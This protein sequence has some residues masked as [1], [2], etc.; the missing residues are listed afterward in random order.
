MES[1]LEAIDIEQDEYT[2]YDSQGRLLVLK[3]EFENR[4]PNQE[5]KVEAA[6]SE[7]GHQDEL[8]NTLIAY[9]KAINVDDSFL[10]GKSNEQMI[11]M[12]VERSG[13]AEDG[14]GSVEGETFFKLLFNL[15]RG[16]RK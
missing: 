13:Y 1:Y 5:I 15:I 10:N 12:I 7:P 11:E 14:K 3:A 8:R 2:A 4:R 6:E 16:K 9:L